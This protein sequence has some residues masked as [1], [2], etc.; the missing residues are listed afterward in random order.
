MDKVHESIKNIN[1]GTLQGT[2]DSL[3]SLYEI[4]STV[5]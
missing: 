1:K 4:I 2:K 5:D 3:K